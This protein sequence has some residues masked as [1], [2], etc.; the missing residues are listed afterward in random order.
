MPHHSSGETG[1]IIPPRCAL[2]LQGD[3]L[4]SRLLQSPTNGD[5]R[6]VLRPDDY[7]YLVPSVANAKFLELLQIEFA[8]S[9]R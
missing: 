3:T 4:V 6:D 8:G 5:D 7:I 9:V 1:V 2:R